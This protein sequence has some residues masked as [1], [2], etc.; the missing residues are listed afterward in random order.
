M[1]TQNLAC[2]WPAPT[3]GPDVSSY[4]I[5]GRVGTTGDFSQL[6]TGVAPNASDPQSHTVPKADV[7]SNLNNPADGDTIQVRVIGVGSA[8]SP[9]DPSPTA[10]TTVPSA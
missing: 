2:E 4:T 9:S 6:A 3:S 5:E 7:D 1:P 8:G 10:Q